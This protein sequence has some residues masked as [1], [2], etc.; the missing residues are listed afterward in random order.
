MS[1]HTE[2]VVADF[3]VAPAI[4]NESGARGLGQ[5]RLAVSVR[6]RSL[7]APTRSRKIETRRVVPLITITVA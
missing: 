1:R 6:E 2:S 4:T 5:G 3:A 7:D